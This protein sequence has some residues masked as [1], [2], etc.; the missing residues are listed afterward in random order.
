[1][2]A[3]W[4]NAEKTAFWPDAAT[5]LS[6]LPARRAADYEPIAD[7]KTPAPT[8]ADIFA[9]RDRRLAAGFDFDFGDARGVHRIGTTPADMSGWSEVRAL[10]AARVATDDATA[11]TVATDTGVIEI[12]PSEWPAIDMAAAAFRQPIWAA[13][14]AL[15]AMD[16]I[17]ADFAADS[18]WPDE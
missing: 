2:T 8:A 6:V 17:P 1:M 18:Y 7:F 13:S 11:I 16:P 15:T 12:A 5:K 10:A 4:C 9:E 14:F 3:Q